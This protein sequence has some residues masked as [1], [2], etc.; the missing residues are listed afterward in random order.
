MPSYKITIPIAKTFEEREIIFP[1]FFKADL[2]CYQFVSDSSY[3]RIDNN[4]ETTGVVYNDA[5]PYDHNKL[6]NDILV[7]PEYKEIDKAKFIYLFKIAQSK[8]QY[9]IDFNYWKQ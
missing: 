3:I 6:L 9:Q 8:I 1:I 2:H 5:T 7:D 4:D